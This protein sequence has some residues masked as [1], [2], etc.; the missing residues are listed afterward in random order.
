[1][2][3]GFEPLP[4]IDVD[5]LIHQPRFMCGQELSYDVFPVMNVF[6][7]NSLHR[8]RMLVEIALA[9]H[10]ARARDSKDPSAGGHKAV[11]PHSRARVKDFYSLHSVGSSMPGFDLPLS[12]EPG[13]RRTP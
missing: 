3:G 6:P 8:I 1:M 4:C 11:W 10:S 12:Y 2:Q 5:E 13:I 7:A 9:I